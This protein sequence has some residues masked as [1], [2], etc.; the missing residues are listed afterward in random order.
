LIELAWV[1]FPMARKLDLPSITHLIL[2][3]LERRIEGGFS[4]DLPIPFFY[5]RRGRRV[6]EL[7]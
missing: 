7:L 4:Q 3:E 1:T 2:D 5:E 6:R